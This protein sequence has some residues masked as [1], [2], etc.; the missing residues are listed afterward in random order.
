MEWPAPPRQWRKPPWRVG[1]RSGPM[2]IAVLEIDLGKNSCSV[3][4]LNGTGEVVLPRRMRRDTVVT[5]TS[6]L[7]PCIIAIEAC[8]GAHHLGRLL[9]AQGHSIRLMSPEYVR[10]YVKAQKIGDRTPRRL[11]KPRPGPPC[12]SPSS[13]QR[14]SLTS[15]PCIRCARV[16]SG[17]GRRSRTSSVR[18]FSSGAI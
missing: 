8:C 14:S 2:Q 7:P 9:A 4:G 13:S 11:P 18:S 1:D 6:A 17:P 12:A 5:L 3:V 16:S 10:P 15:S